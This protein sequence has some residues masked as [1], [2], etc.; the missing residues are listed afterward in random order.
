MSTGSPLHREERM[1]AK[2]TQEELEQP[3]KVYQLDA[4]QN[5]FDS[6]ER[7]ITQGFSTMNTSLQTLITQSQSQVT[8]QQLNENVSAAKLAM[9]QEL[10][11]EVRVINLEYGPLKRNV[12]KF[13]W[14]VIAEAIIIVGQVIYITYLSN[15]NAN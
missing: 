15:I 7:Q 5:R 12:T 1:A 2:K 14:A 11:E 10:K 13:L 4:L 6:F 8:P 9:Q 3:A